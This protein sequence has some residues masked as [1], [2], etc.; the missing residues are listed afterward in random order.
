MMRT[1]SSNNDIP[2]S[3]F[4]QNDPTQ[5]LSTT[6][7]ENKSSQAEKIPTCSVC[8]RALVEGG[9][10][11]FDC[12]ACQSQ[13]HLKCV[14]VTKK[15]LKRLADSGKPWCCKGCLEKNIRCHDESKISNMKDHQLVCKFCDEDVQEG[16]AGLFCEDKCNSWYHAKCVGISAKRFKEL[17]TKLVTWTCNTCRMQLIQNPPESSKDVPDIIQKSFIWGNIKGAEEINDMLLDAYRK[18]RNPRFSKKW[19]LENGNSIF[20]V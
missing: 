3:K 7:T 5:Q 9:K 19:H 10:E 1:R 14:G 2:D 16:Q 12:Y 13:S 20:K 8:E 4:S 17:R 18:T 6:T 11:F 15:E